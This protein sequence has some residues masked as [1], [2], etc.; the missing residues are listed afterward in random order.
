MD[1]S[2]YS[3]KLQKLKTDLK[4]NKDLTIEIKNEIEDT[5]N[6][7]YFLCNDSIK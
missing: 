3:N 7:L 5:K 1:F 2:F 4:K 6:Q